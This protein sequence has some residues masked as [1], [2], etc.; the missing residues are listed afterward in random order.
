MECVDSIVP[1]PFFFR[2]GG[3]EC[4]YGWEWWGVVDGVGVGYLDAGDLVVLALALFS[5]GSQ[6]EENRF[7]WIRERAKGRRRGGREVGRKVGYVRRM[8]DFAPAAGEEG[9]CHL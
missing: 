2:R 9:D 4:G 1:P 7:Q 8:Q 6:W 3:G 5:D